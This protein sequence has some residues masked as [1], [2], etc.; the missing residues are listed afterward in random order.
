MSDEF[1]LD[2]TDVSY[3]LNLTGFDS[4]VIQINLNTNYSAS[5]NFLIFLPVAGFFISSLKASAKA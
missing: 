3:N 4:S 5:I 1:F 2:L